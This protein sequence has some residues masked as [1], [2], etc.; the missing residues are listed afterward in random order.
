MNEKEKHIELFESYLTNVLDKKGI[1]EFE[2]RL[3]TDPDFANQFDSYRVSIR[4]IEYEG[5][6]LEM[7]AIIGA[8]KSTGINYWKYAVAACLLLAI[9]VAV[10]LV[11]KQNKDPFY[12]FFEP[13]PNVLAM[14][15][16][17]TTIPGM[18]S[19]SDKQWEESIDQLKNLT[20]RTDTILFYLSMAQLNNGDYSNALLNLETVDPNSLFFPQV[21]WYKALAYIKVE[22]ADSSL[23]LLRQIT[24]QTYKYKEA[25][26]LIELLD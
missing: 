8:N 25:E 7:A 24:P 5:V 9:G 10:W 1:T 19:Y 17:N 16:E 11:P 23:A 15:S 6:K 14:R 26:Q 22:Q 13:Y 3:K 18:E 2:N 4:L 21:L 12:D 20:P